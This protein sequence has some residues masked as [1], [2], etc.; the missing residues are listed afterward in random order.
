MEENKIAI[1][2]YMIK[3]CTL[4][5]AKIKNNKIQVRD[6]IVTYTVHLN[7]LQCPCGKCNSSGLCNHV[8]FLLNTKFRL[9][10]DVIT[11]IHKLFPIFI[12][13]INKPNINEILSQKL[14]GEILTDECGI[15]IEKLHDSK[16]DVIE[17]NQ[18]EKYCHKKCLYKWLQ[19]NKKTIEDQNKK[20]IYC[21]T[22][23]FEESTGKNKLFL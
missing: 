11:F 23:T 19:A 5:I 14:Y 15:C 13:N 2:K 18:C 3:T 20:C 8:I 4:S 7:P 10:Y 6:G 17:C 9:S 21:N 1:N 12:E 22:G 16:H